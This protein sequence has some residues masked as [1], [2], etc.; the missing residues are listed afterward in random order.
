MSSL[1][2][3][4]QDARDIGLPKDVKR[5]ENRVRRM[6]MGIAQDSDRIGKRV[7]ILLPCRPLALRSFIEYSPSVVN[8]AAKPS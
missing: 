1:E 6:V 4:E 2:D 3:V 8:I 7:G 5:L